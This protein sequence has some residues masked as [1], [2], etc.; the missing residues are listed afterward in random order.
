MTEKLATEE[1]VR[2]KATI[3]QL[4]K[5]SKVTK[6]VTINV[7]DDS[8]EVVEVDMVFQGISAKEYDVLKAGYK[9]NQDQK[10]LGLDY[11]PEKF[12]PVLLARCCIDPVM[13]EEDAKEIWESD[14]WN[15]GE[16]MQ[17][18]MACI[19]VCTRGLDVPFNSSD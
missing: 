4:K 13:S 9:P 17:L 12:G 14:N 8:G 3:D 2:P 7:S 15:R 10:K 6:T 11:D 5:K 16:R 18:L 19:E 1:E